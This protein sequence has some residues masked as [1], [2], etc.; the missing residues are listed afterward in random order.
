MALGFW[1][2]GLPL[3]VFGLCA[4]LTAAERVTVTAGAVLFLLA[5]LLI[6]RAKP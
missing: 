6:R 3:L 1:G 4:S 5:G 2:M